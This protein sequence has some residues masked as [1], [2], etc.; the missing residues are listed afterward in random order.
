LSSDYPGGVRHAL[1]R[2]VGRELPVVFL[3][4]FCGDLRPPATGRWRRSGSLPRRL[5]LLASSVVNGPGF[6]AFMPDE[7]Q[8]W[9]N[10]II[11]SGGR[12]TDAAAQAPPLRAKLLLRR[13]T[14]AL[15]K[16]GLS[17][18]TSSVTCHWFD[19]GDGLRIVGISAEVCWEYMPLVQRAFSTKTVW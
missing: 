3:Q 10:G 14:F 8:R 7:Y 12:G 2:H 15:S 1:R 11:A 13:S 16:F 17:G 9:R 6:T 4:G 18:E 5:L 19:L